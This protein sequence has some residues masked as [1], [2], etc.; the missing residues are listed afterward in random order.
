LLKESKRGAEKDLAAKPEGDVAAKA[1]LIRT[2]GGNSCS[3]RPALIS[4]DVVKGQRWIPNFK[5][6]VGA[7]CS[8]ANRLEQGQ[9]SIPFPFPLLLQRARWTPS[10][11]KYTMAIAIPQDGVVGG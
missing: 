7:S 5:R 10:G 8:C 11:G 3:A 6:A 9:P 1:I 4:G 2:Y